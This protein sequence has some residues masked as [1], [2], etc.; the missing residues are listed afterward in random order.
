MAAETESSDPLYL[1]IAHSL[2]KEIVGGVFPVGTQLPTEE[3]LCRRFSVSRYT[4]RSAL[5]RLRDDGLIN[6]RRGAGTT[7]IAPPSMSM[8]SFGAMSIE[9]LLHFASGSYINIQHIGMVQIDKLLAQRTGLKLGEDWLFV[10]ALGFNVGS[11]IPL[12]HAEYYIHQDFAGVSRLLATHKVPIF[13]LIEDLF[14]V[15]MA[16]VNQDISATLP[17]VELAA[18]LMIEPGTPALE[19]RHTYRLATGKIAQL[20]INTH[21]AGRYRHTVTMRRV[22]A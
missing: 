11:D 10:Q 13:P 3:D 18:K 14:G 6:S 8:R 21:P 16:E 20:T 7:V 2:K 17:T 4:V 22:K 12:G 9:D 1:Q 19:V 5:G 15:T